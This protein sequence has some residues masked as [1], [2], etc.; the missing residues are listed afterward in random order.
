MASITDNPSL[1]REVAEAGALPF[2]A[3]A[4]LTGDQA[5]NACKTLQ[6]AGRDCLV[7]GPPRSG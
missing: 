4:G 3:A 2:L 6:K 5:R 7:V 1:V